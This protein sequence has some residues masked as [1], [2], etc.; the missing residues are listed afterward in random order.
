MK[1]LVSHKDL[2]EILFPQCSSK[3]AEVKHFG[4]CE[5][6]SFCQ[7]KFDK[8]GKELKCICGNPEFGLNCVCE[9]VSDNPG[10]K[11]FS[12][13]FD[14]IYTASKPRCNKCEEIVNL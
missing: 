5:C 13:E 6:E 4:V 10:D 14:G 2:K 7:H 11:E 3:C 12:C 8:D 9:F 1:N